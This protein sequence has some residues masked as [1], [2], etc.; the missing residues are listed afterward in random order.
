MS[1]PLKS[2]K[3][4]LASNL[5]SLAVAGATPQVDD[6]IKQKMVK[7]IYTVLYIYIDYRY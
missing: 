6:T 2:V 1:K 5:S 3:T 4:S 7:Y